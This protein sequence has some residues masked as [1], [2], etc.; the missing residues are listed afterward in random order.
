ML[1]DL[2]QFQSQIM[3]NEGGNSQ[4]PANKFALNSFANLFECNLSSS[5]QFTEKYKDISHN[6]CLVLSPS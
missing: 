1:H 6:I 2:S 4:A 3:S 5:T